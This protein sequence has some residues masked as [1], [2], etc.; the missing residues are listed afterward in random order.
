MAFVS[1]KNI[2]ADATRATPQQID[3]WQKSWRTAVTGG[4]QDSL[5]DFVC[6]EASNVNAFR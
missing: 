6:R 1:L 4:S 2:V 3:D 5:L